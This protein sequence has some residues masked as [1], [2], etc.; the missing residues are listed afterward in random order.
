MSASPD[1]HDADHD[2]IVTACKTYY[3]TVCR[4]FRYKQPDLALQAEA[5]K[6]SARSR[7]RRKR[8]LEARRC[9][10]GEDDVGI[11]KCATIDLISDEVQPP[12]RSSQSSVLRCSRD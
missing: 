1:F 4:N 2:D 10:L 7:A 9:V 5:V 3:E 8:L 12:A 11:W 6:S